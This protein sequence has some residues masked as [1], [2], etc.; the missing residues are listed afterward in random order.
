MEGGAQVAKSRRRLTRFLAATVLVA[1]YAVSTLV[2]SGL[3]LTTGSTPAAAKKKGGGGGGG[4]SRRRRRRGRG[5]GIFLGTGV[6]YCA[7]WSSE[8]SD[9]YGYRTKRYYRCMRGQGC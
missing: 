9:L 5:T 8:C 7:Y 4:G 2:V 6:S 3:A 1:M